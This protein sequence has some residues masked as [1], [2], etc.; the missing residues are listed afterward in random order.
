MKCKTCIENKMHNLR[1]SNN[2][3][4]AKVILEIVHTDVCGPFKPTEFNGENY[5]VSFIDDYSKI[6]KVYCIKTKD[7]VFNCLVKFINECENLSEK[8]VKVL[9]CDNGNEYLNNRFYKFAEEKGIILNNCPVYV[10]ELNGT[11]E[12]FN[13]TIMNMARYLLTEANV[14]KRF[15]PEIICAATY[16]K[17]QTLTNTIERKTPYEIFFNKRPNVKHLRLYGSRVFVRKPEKKNF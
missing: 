17:N 16:L 15:R 1:F 12:S 2:R 7:E 3:I 13:S 9:R 4:K 6:A 8:K 10:H 11:A 14:H 5:F